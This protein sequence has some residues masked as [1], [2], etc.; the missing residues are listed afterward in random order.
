[1]KIHRVYI[2]F[3]F[4][5]IVFLINNIISLYFS[6]KLIYNNLGNLAKK[7][8]FKLLKVNFKNKNYNMSNNF[9]DD[10]DALFEG[11]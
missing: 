10:I 7:F 8:N 9:D 6:N 2:F 11:L 4:K 3:E 1:M 5:N